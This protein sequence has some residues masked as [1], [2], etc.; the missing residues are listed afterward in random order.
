MCGLTMAFGCAPTAD[1]VPEAQVE[2]STPKDAPTASETPEVPKSLKERVKL[3]ID[4]VRQR[5]LRT[6]N[7]F[8]TVFHGI[9]AFGDGL[10]LLDDQTGDHINAVDYIL[11]GNYDRGQ[12]RG[13]RFTP[14]PNGLEVQ[15][16]P[17]YVGQGHQDQFVAILAQWDVPIDRKVI[18][19]QHEY[20]VR[21][22][23]TQIQADARIGAELSW[24][25]IVLGK[26]LETDKWTNSAGETLTYEDLIR[27]ELDNTIDK[28]ACGGTH[29]LIGLTWAY[30][31]HLSKGNEETPL[32]QEVR[33]KLDRHIE[34]AKENQNPDGSFSTNYFR[35]QATSP[36]AQQRL[37]SCGHTFEWLSS[38]LSEKQLKE[39]WMQDA[40]HALAMMF[41]EI[42][43]EPM[44]SGALYH[45]AHGLVIYYE[46]V[47][48]WDA[49]ENQAAR[50]TTVHN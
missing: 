40:A 42:Q 6:H 32:W 8:W 19:Y 41:L 5:D 14:T 50:A 22:F 38:V 24:T 11:A 9:L 13:M 33:A 18:V 16:G 15:M 2:T 21:D 23:V 46:R 12:I 47:F 4:L 1:D 20:T 35:N 28:A 10:A 27:S 34:L 43:S 45:A 30:H 39:Q 37:N 3:A 31:H 48:G 26:Y 36:D 49:I 7:A 25:I 29:R 44:E 17:T